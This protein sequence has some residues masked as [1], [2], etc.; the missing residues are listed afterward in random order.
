M[1]NIT[2]SRLGAWHTDS[3]GLQ[4]AW[5]LTSGPQWQGAVRVLP[6]WGPCLPQCFHFCLPSPV[7][8]LVF[9]L[10]SLR[11]QHLCRVPICLAGILKHLSSDMLECLLVPTPPWLQTA[12]NYGATEETDTVDGLILSLI[13]VQGLQPPTA[14][15]LDSMSCVLRVW[16]HRFDLHFH[17]RSACIHP[18]CPCPL[19]LFLGTFLQQD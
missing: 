19:L 9:P 8:L 2:W 4:P 5:K 10:V 17:I 1:S 16:I 15:P 14:D 3:W 7:V 18:R 6:S 13:M 11:F 12:L